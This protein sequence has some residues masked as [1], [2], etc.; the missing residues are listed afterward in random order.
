[1][2]AGKERPGLITHKV[3]NQNSSQSVVEPQ[4]LSTIGPQISVSS[5]IGGVVKAIQPWLSG[6]SSKLV[7]SSSGQNSCSES[8]PSGNF[9]K[10]EPLDLMHKGSLYFQRTT[11]VHF[12]RNRDELEFAVGELFD[13]VFT[14]AIKIDV[15]RSYPLSEAA[16]A[17]RDLEDRKTTGSVVYVP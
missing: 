11:G 17:H 3:M 1:M 13:L 6:A 2:P 9:P 15:S 8:S 7:L 16:Q 12:A 14:G 4:R 10:V 5:T